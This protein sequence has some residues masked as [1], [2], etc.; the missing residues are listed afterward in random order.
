MKETPPVS[1]VQL[2]HQAGRLQDQ[3]KCFCWMMAMV[4]LM[5]AALMSVATAGTG[6]ILIAKDYPHSFQCQSGERFFP[7]GDTAYFLIAQPTNV[8]ARFIDSRRAH[9][10][11]FIRMMPM[12]RGHWVFGGTPRT[13]DYEAINESAMRK[14]DWVF[15]YA[16]SHGMH[17]E[18]IVFGYGV[19]QGEGLWTNA[20]HLSFW[21]D[22]LVKRYK[23]RPNLFMWTVANEFE[24]YP[25]GRYNY[26]PGDVEWVKS[27]AAQIRRTDATHPI[28]AHPSI[29]ITKDDP[30]QRYGG[31]TQRRPQVVWPLWEDSLI[32]LNVTQNNEGAQP[33][34]WGNFTPTNRG[35]TYYSTSWQGAE[36]P[37]QWTTE[38]WDFEAAG[39]E[40]CIAEDWSHGKPVLNTEFGYQYEA[41]AEESYGART[42]QFATVGTV[43]KKAWKIATAGGYFAAGYRNLAVNENFT[44][45]EVDNFRPQQL[46]ILYYFFTTKTEYWKM[47]PHLELVA[48]HNVLLAQP[49]KEYVA[50]F[51][52]G[53]TNRV[54]LN[55][56][57]Y[58]VEW[59]RAETGQYYTL[60]SVTVAGGGREFVPPNNHT[61]D[62]VL[63]LRQ[64]S[65]VTRMDAPS[66]EPG[67]TTQGM[68]GFPAPSEL[69]RQ[70][71]L[72]DPLVMLDGRKAASP[73]MWKRERR[74]ELIGLF[75]HY[76]YGEFPS[77]PHVS[78]K[79]ERVDRAALGGK[80]TLSEV[81]LRFGPPETPPIHLMLIMPNRSAR[82]PVVL[83]LNYYGNHTLVHDKNVRLP[84]NWMPGWS[85]EAATA[86]KV[87]NNRAT[88]AGRGS[89]TKYWPVEDLIDR[90][91]AL[92]TFYNGDIDPDAPDQRVFRKHFPQANPADEC[93]SIGAWAWGLQR[94]VDYLV[95]APGID[96]RRIV[97]TGH[98]RTAKAALVA[99]AFDER[100]ALAIP[101]QAGC[102]GTAP[103]RARIAIG[104]TYN[105]LNTP[106]TKPPETVRDIND[107]FPH[108]FN[109]RFKEFN[110]EPE[111]LPFDQHC[112]VALCA[113]RPV[114]FTNGRA[115]TWI[116][117]A[118]QFEVLRAAAPVYRLLGAGDFT[119]E[120][121]PRDRQL[122]DGTLGY[123][124]RPGAHSL[125]REDW[126]VFLDYAD[127]HLR[128][129]P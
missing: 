106:Q 108:W 27:V 110:T 49:G 125:L 119:A 87:V 11:N 30:F 94:A 101:H 24:R 43:R 1:F 59:L 86:A 44:V 48:S 69:P 84:D 23:D 22:S 64:E 107:K 118:G 33:R 42:R 3:A 109:E 113:P 74:P 68:A 8:I 76:M 89:W 4:I 12:A 9:K 126:K 20:A 128:S 53:G 116:N 72:P 60:P 88:E 28:G 40:D 96:P 90:G 61:A 41:G 124:L 17:I 77:K 129:M 65:A 47:A 93:G 120:E 111:R 39:M 66:L 52:R 97:V 103:S 26:S 63:H 32:N 79:V 14:L 25:D 6:P 29:W 35:L 55:T 117:P 37:V 71:F 51:P 15:D 95:T 10:F 105:T 115:D 122:I 85:G 16:S 98:S 56:G 102:G 127:K 112:L 5:Q 99:A 50:Y 114:L 57:T 31:F 67:R 82:V 45:K 121:L 21:I 58:T 83:A 54:D 78:A 80:A 92:A 81:T 7:M 18:L 75:Q 46:E 13:P 100:I 19:E 123:Y 70:A 62:W 2:L 73:E 38:G 91:Y 104:K 36:Y 34:T